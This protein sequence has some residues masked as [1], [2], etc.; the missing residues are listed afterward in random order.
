MLTPQVEHDG[1]QC[2]DDDR[3]NEPGGSSEESSN[4]SADLEDD[5]W[6]E[7]DYVEEDEEVY[8]YPPP[9]ALAAIRA[10]GNF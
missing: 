7:D 2:G 6:G 4:L 9:E 8:G 1:Y 5:V 10:H 3:S